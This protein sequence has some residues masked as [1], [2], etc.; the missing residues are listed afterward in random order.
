M[1]LLNTL[2]VLNIAYKYNNYVCGIINQNVPKIFLQNF[3]SITPGINLNTK[4]DNLGQVYRTPQELKDKTD[5][6]VIGRQFCNS[7]DPKKECIK[8]LE[9]F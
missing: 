8:I 6:L 1:K 5:I 9:N 4:G 3:L 2:D 7:K